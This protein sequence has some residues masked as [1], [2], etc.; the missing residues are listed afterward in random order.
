MTGKFE[1]DRC[2]FCGGTLKPGSATIPFIVESSV[3]II[4]EI[5]AL[6]CTQCSEPIMSSEGAATV[7]TLLK[8]AVKSGFELSV[9]TCEQPTLTL[10]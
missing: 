10:A 4:K 8:Q 7:D 3:I 6:V 9:V 5:P 2:Y 1:N